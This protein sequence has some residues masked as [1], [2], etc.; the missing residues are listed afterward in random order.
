MASLAQSRGGPAVPADIAEILTKT[1]AKLGTSAGVDLHSADLAKAA[2]AAL[3]DA[4]AKRDRA[5]ALLAM[6]ALRDLIVRVG[7]HSNLILDPDLDSYYTMDLVLLRLPDLVS[8]T[9]DL[10]AAL[11]TGAKGA[12]SVAEQADILV[13]KGAMQA[14][15]DGVT[16]S[17]SLGYRSNAS[18]DLKRWIDTDMQGLIA[19]GAAM[20]QAA[21]AQVAGKGPASAAKLTADLETALGK[22][23]GA[24]SK[25]LENLLTIRINGFFQA[26]TW[27]LVLVAIVVLL[28]VT[29]ALIIG[30]SVSRPMLNLT[31]QMESLVTGSTDVKISY[32]KRGDEVGKIAK[33]VE[34]FRQALV[35]RGRLEGEQRARMA[36]DLALAERRVDAVTEFRQDLESVI[37]AVTQA[38]ERMRQSSAELTGVVAAT[39]QSCVAMATSSDQTL[40]TVQMMAAATD[41]LSSSIS[42][43]GRQ[44]ESSTGISRLA[45]EEVQSADKT[46][47]DLENATAQIGDIVTLIQAIAAQTNLLALN[48][49]IE[50]A[51]AGEAGKGFA[52]V[53]TEVKNLATQTAGATE[54]IQKSVETMRALT[55]AASRTMI[56]V[57]DRVME[58]DMRMSSVA[59]AVEEQTAATRDIARNVSQAAEGAAVIADA[60]SGVTSATGNAAEAANGTLDLSAALESSTQSLG[61][62][63]DRFTQRLAAVGAD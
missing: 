10:D 35:E 34:F 50:A 43:I 49:T 23:Y 56:S 51:R 22:G 39:N 61:L 26:M 11:R 40:Q 42:E 18:G 62:A 47:H 8:R 57:R 24:A 17:V 60:I 30:R 12:P 54:D 31:G 33:A 53:A 29:L 37:W 59:V 9:A 27:S 13:A 16:A 2:S 14:T 7:D 19:A 6:T 20:I 44:V 15:L 48:A 28:A 1:E 36:A 45:A 41:E 46:L 52:V 4:A 3:R 25:A 32:Q 55:H 63:L 5:S 21:D 38:V 58:T